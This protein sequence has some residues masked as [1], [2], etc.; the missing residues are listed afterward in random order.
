V[1][2]K[3]VY[4]SLLRECLSGLPATFHYGLAANEPEF[5]TLAAWLKEPGRQAALLRPRLMIGVLSPDRPPLAS[6]TT[7]FDLP[8]DVAFDV[9]IRTFLEETVSASE[10]LTARIKALHLL[11]SG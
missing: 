9:M 1:V 5:D 4:I 6:V 8:G 10:A 3:S 11:R 2:E 7:A